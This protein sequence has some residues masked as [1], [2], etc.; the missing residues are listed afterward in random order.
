GVGAVVH[1]DPPNDHKDY[2]H[3][4]GRTARAGARGLVVSL[5]PDDMVKATRRMQADLGMPRG[6]SS[7]DV[8]SLQTE[9][10]PWAGEPT[11]NNPSPEGSSDPRRPS[12]PRAKA[13]YGQPRHGQSSSESTGTGRPARPQANGRPSTSPAGARSRSGGSPSGQKARS[14]SPAAGQK[15]RSGAP[16]PNRA[17]RAGR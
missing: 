11:Q 15:A 1:F 5:I 4:S 10:D 7:P 8:A 13:G 9:T 16:R 12:P 17:R 2:I 6:I 3:R 14:G